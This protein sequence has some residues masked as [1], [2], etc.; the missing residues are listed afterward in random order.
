ML[1]YKHFPKYL[2]LCTAKQIHL[3]KFGT[4]WGSANDDRI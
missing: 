2:P 4:T 1:G 3:Y